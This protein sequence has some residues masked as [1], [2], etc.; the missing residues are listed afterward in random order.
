MRT[1]KAATAKEWY[2]VEVRYPPPRQVDLLA[3]EVP[4]REAAF[5][6]ARMI[7]ERAE[8]T[9]K[10]LPAS[11]VTEGGEL[12]VYKV[13]SSPGGGRLDLNR[14]PKEAWSEG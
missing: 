3:S 12:T 1:L 14:I 4:D 8:V 7:V 6:L 5:A 13:R 11:V 9:R 10:A 2:R